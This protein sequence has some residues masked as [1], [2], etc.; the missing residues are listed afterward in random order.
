M[1]EVPDNVKIEVE[2][3]RRRI[4]DPY[5]DGFVQWGNKQKLY[6]ILFLVEDEL[7]KCPTFSPED[8]FLTDRKLALA[9]RK[10]SGEN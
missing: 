6:E 4:T 1:Y 3:L 9:E 2:W 8:E 10:L 7:A 5:E